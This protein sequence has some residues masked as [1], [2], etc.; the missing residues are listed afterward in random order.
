MVGLDNQRS[1]PGHSSIPSSSGSPGSAQPGICSP[2]I[3]GFPVPSE[4]LEKPAQT[5]PRPPPTNS[6]WRKLEERDF[7]GDT[8]RL[9]IIL[10]FSIPSPP[11]ENEDFPK[12]PCLAA[13][14]DIWGCP[15]LL[16]RAIPSS[17]PEEEC[18]ECDLQ[19][20]AVNWQDCC[21]RDSLAQAQREGLKV[22]GELGGTGRKTQLQR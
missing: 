9:G 17:Q 3:L 12:F 4:V 2:R 1:L 14:G 15:E 16:I 10:C 11:R 20:G 13:Q 7:R 6:T 8:T 22:Q 5:Q 19:L 18:L 21:S